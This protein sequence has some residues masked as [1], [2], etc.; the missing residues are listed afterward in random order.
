M[1]WF[2]TAVGEDYE[3]KKGRSYRPFSLPGSKNFTSTFF[4]NMVLTNCNAYGI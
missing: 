1:I 2:L 3:F 4:I